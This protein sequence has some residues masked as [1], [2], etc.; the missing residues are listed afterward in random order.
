MA[1]KQVHLRVP[2]EAVDEWDHHVENGTY[3]SRSD[4][5]M[6]AVDNQ[7]K[8]DN[9][10]LSANGSSGG[11]EPNGRIDDILVR[12]E[13]NGESLERI[14]ERLTRMHDAVTSKGGV[15]DQELSDVYGEIPQS[16]GAGDKGLPPEAIRPT[17]AATPAEIAE[18]AD[19]DVDTAAV[20]LSQL[21]RQYD[22]VHMV[23][24]VG[25]EE[26]TYWKEAS[27]L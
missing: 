5:I 1:S 22:G 9:G 17:D 21:R 13:D 4:L 8:L 27:V 14:E 10:E 2:H 11:S 7:I 25:D 19:V 3:S 15:S 26:P 18:K 24:D 23:M 20:A 6:R 16:H 12:T